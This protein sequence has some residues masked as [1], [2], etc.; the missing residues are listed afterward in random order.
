MQIHISF[1]FLPSLCLL[2]C[3]W[4]ILQKWLWTPMRSCMHAKYMHGQIFVRGCAQCGHRCGPASLWFG[5][6][7]RVTTVSALTLP[8]SSTSGR[9]ESLE[10]EPPSMC[11]CSL[12]RLSTSSEPDASAASLVAARGTQWP[13]PSTFRFHRPYSINYHLVLLFFLCADWCFLLFFLS[14]LL[15]FFIFFYLDLESVSIK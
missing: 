10:E 4:F 3:V 14:L 9:L 8:R 1:R 5:R 12:P 6:L 11:S 15:F 7:S 13:W 2:V